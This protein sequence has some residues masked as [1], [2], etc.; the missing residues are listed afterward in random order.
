MGRP[1]K[2]LAI[3][4]KHFT[5]QEREEREEEELNVP[6]TDVKPPDYLTAQQKKEFNSYASKL[7]ALNIFT[8]LDVDILAQFIIA[9]SLYLEYT[10]QLKKVLA[11]KNA[12]HKWAAIDML[13]DD[14]EDAEELKKLLEKILRRQRGDDATVI[15]NL[16]DKAH[17]QC[18]SCAKEL[19]LTVTSRLKLAM[20][21]PPDDDDDEL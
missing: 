9:R 21:K 4:K 8:E 5:K 7:V 2:P 6:Y 10:D 18:I 11:K 17:K 16:Q 1:R 20:P 19:G 14:C 15:M 3:N 12:V 13:A